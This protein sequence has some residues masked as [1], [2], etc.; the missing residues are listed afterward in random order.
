MLD[1]ALQ[2]VDAHAVDVGQ[3]YAFA[4]SDAVAAALMSEHVEVLATNAASRSAMLC[5]VSDGTLLGLCLAGGNLVPL[6]LPP[7]TFAPVAARVRETRRRFSSIVGPQDQVLGMWEPLKPYVGPAR[8][9]RVDQPSMMIDTDPA[10]TPDVRVRPAVESDI[11]VLLPACVAMFTEEVGYS[12]LTGGGGYERRIRSLVASGRSLVW[13]ADT[14]HGRD[15][16]FKAEVGALGLGVAQV[17][18]V[19]VHPNYR[20]Q[21]ISAPGMAAV[22]N[23]VRANLAPVVSLYVNAFNTAAIA[24]YRRTGFRQVGTYATILL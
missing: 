14:P 4:H 21:G 18:G 10:I 3:I 22:V 16:V 15:V 19:W 17:Q 1:S 24:A 12:P 6:G 13:I 2:I 9:E 8:D 11:D 5:V 23:Y 7:E 20:G